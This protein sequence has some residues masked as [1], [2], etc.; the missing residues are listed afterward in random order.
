MAGA[1]SDNAILNQFGELVE[2][3]GSGLD[4]FSSFLETKNNIKASRS[5]VTEAPNQAPRT[6]TVAGFSLTTKDVAIN[7]AVIG[8]VILAGVLIYKMVK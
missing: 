2:I 7:A 5:A 6:G 3:A 8:A 1:Y 4:R